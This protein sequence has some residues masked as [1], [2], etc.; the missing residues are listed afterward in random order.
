MKCVPNVEIPPAPLV[1]IIEFTSPIILFSFNLISNF[2]YVSEYLR[3]YPT[4]NLF[5]LFFRRSIPSSACFN[6]LVNG[7]SHMIY[8]I[9]FLIAYFRIS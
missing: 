4:D 8:F 9:F 3:K 6:Y 7:F 2:E 1:I 5:S